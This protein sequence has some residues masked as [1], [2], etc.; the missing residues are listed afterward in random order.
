MNAREFAKGL[1]PVQIRRTLR[2]ARR[3]VPVRLRD[4]TSIISDRSARPDLPPA[5]LRLRVARTS[6]RAEFVEV[7]RVVASS[8]LSSALSSGCEVAA[9]QILDFGCGCGRVARHIMASVPSA[10]LTGIDLDREAINWCSTHLPGRFLVAAALPP[11]PLPTHTF[12]LIYAVSVFTHLDEP[13]QDSWL[14]EIARLLKPG[15]LLLASTHNPVLTFERPD[16]S[17]SHHRVLQATGF[18]FAAGSGPLNEQSAFHSDEYLRT[19]WS[20]WFQLIAYTQHGL[21]GYQDL[22]VWRGRA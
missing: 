18:L 16:L 9:R 22:G 10:F 8:L 5:S 21:A 3:E 14:A 1:I 12:D 13:A 20:R 17:E 6:S 7:G 2:A 4:L 15:G 19:H 11:T